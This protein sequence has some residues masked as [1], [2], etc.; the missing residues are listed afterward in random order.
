MD[1]GRNL[2][3]PY[4]LT[5]EDG[6]VLRIPAHFDEMTPEQKVGWPRRAVRP[7][8]RRR[9]TLAAAIALVFAAAAA[10]LKLPLA[11]T[12]G[13]LGLALDILGGVMLAE[14][15]LMSDEDARYLST[16]GGIENRHLLAMRDARQAAAGAILLVLGFV[17]QLIAALQSLLASG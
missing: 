14:G 5:R 8:L 4:V 13:S 6:V 7:W 2:D 1:V 17:G 10:A 11:G 12:A 3:E 16:Y 15:V 9:L